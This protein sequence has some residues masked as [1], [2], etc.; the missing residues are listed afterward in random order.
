MTPNPILATEVP[1]LPS[2][3][4]PATT[5]HTRTPVPPPPSRPIPAAPSHLWHLVPSL[6][7][8]PSPAHTSHPWSSCLCLQGHPMSPPV[9]SL[10]PVCVLT[11]LGMSAQRAGTAWQVWASAGGSE[12][13]QCHLVP[14]PLPSAP[15]LSPTVSPPHAVLS[16]TGQG[17]VPHRAGAV[18]HGGAMSPSRGPRA[19]PY[20]PQPLA[21]PSPTQLQVQG[22]Q[23]PCPGG[24]PSGWAQSLALSR[25]VLVHSCP[26]CPSRSL[27][28]HSCPALSPRI[29]PAQILHWHRTSEHFVLSLCLPVPPHPLPCPLLSVP[30]SH[31]LPLVSSV[32]HPIPPIPPHPSLPVPSLPSLL[33]LS[34]SCPLHDSPPPRGTHGTP[35]APSPPAPHGPSLP[36]VSGN[37]VPCR[38]PHRD[39][40]VS[41]CSPSPRR[42]G[43]AGWGVPALRIGSSCGPWGPWL[44]GLCCCPVP[45]GVRQRPG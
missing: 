36:G 13:Q 39:P 23:K 10:V 28:S 14:C 16:S 5:S 22:A 34:P 30:P 1:S 43:P 44:Q 2:C 19:V 27:L 41:L 45:H 38:G 3:P 35:V 17:T 6:L 24:V 21:A 11:H 12:A 4:I 18:P 33:T 20:L 37:T 32:P 8:C 26:L 42:G 7:P 25:P 31:P 9:P 29:T 15:G 40:A